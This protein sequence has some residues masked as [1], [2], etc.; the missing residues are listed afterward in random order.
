[1]E[2]KPATGTDPAKLFK[3]RIRIYPAINPGNEFYL[4]IM[5]EKQDLLSTSVTDPETNLTRY[6]TIKQNGSVPVASTTQAETDIRKFQTVWLNTVAPLY[7]QYIFDSTRSF[8]YSIEEYDE[9]LSNATGYWNWRQYQSNQSPKEM[10][11]VFPIIVTDD[12]SYPSHALFKLVFVPYNQRLLG[13]YRRDNTRGF[14]DN[15]D[16]CP[17]KCPLNDIQ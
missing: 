5:S 6:Y 13:G 17:E 7:P 10:V 9:L 4:L 11:K 8:T 16:V 2:F 12:P 3:N 15:M 14:F 1:M